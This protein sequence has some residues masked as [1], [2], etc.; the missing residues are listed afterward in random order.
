MERLEPPT[1][2]IQIPLLEFE[3]LHA[4]IRELEAGVERGHSFLS[5]GFAG[6][7]KQE[8]EALLSGRDRA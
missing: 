5:F 2:Y 4:R 6:K 3:R 8:L 7:A 1:I